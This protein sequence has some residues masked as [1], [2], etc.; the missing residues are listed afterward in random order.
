MHK[1]E[2]STK[3]LEAVLSAHILT[4]YRVS[5]TYLDRL[6]T[7]LSQ[8]P[9][10]WQT[11]TDVQISV[12][13]HPNPAFRQK[14]F[15]RRLRMIP[16]APENDQLRDATTRFVNYLASNPNAN[17]YDVTFNCPA[18]H[19]GIF[20]GQEN[21]EINV[22]CVMTGGHIPEDIFSQRPVDF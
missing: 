11:H 21:Q 22:I 2:Q 9:D 7:S 3:V 20:C 13:Q 4:Q 8:R 6:I 18:Q 16:T 19:Y 17:I 1:L 12:S 14:I 15:Q 10:V 5:D